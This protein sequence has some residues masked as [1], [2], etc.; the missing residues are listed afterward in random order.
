M[1]AVDFASLGITVDTVQVKS[2]IADLDELSKRAE[3]V[4]P[5]S[6]KAASGISKTGDAAKAAAP[7]INDMS[8]AMQLLMGKAGEFVPGLDSIVSTFSK[9][10]SV[11][12]VVV[13]GLAAIGGAFAFITEQTVVYEK[14]LKK[15]SEETGLSVETMSRYA[16]IAR[17]SGTSL[18]TLTGAIVKYQRSAEAAAAGTG[19]QSDALRAL[20]FAADGSDA[21]FEAV[22]KSLAAMEDGQ[23]KNA[24][25]MTLLGRGA[26]EV[27]EVMLDI[28]RNGDAVGNVTAQQADEADRLVRGWN[29]L[30]GVMSDWTHAVASPVVEYLDTMLTKFKSLGTWVKDFKWNDLS[31]WDPNEA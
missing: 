23:A 21:S 13:G 26:R 29:N 16:V 17:E 3:Q 27:N 10:S 20:G 9:F 14:E 15:L 6:A 31:T 25:S 18:D 19:K 22:A 4:E 5:A 24:L 1:S 30:K 11:S 2:A 8:G 7:G 28:A 12:G